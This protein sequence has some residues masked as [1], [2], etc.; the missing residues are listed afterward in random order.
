VV[1]E[2]EMGK[3]RWKSTM[4]EVGIH[5]SNFTVHFISS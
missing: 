3:G 4:K 5:P 1:E 2:Q